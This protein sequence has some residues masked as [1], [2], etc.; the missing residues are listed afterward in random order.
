MRAT[1]LTA[2][3]VAAVVAGVAAPVAGSPGTTTAEDRCVNSVAFYT[4][5][6]PNPPPVRIGY[7]AD[8]NDRVFFVASTDGEIVGHTALQTYSG[9]VAVDGQ[10]VPLDEV[11]SG[12][13]NLTVTVYRDANG[14]GQF[15]A[16]ADEPCTYG[17]DRVD[18]TQQF[19]F[20]NRTT[21]RPTG[22]VTSTET[23]RETVTGTPPESGPGVPGFGVGVA[24]LAVTAAALLAGRR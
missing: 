9:H 18:A 10:E 19:Y 17:G 22:S 7:S 12:Y 24:V 5:T 14:N 6:D 1:A 2:L 15:D 11:P 20:G 3:L 21:H 23:T 16:D 13:A 4:V 8:S